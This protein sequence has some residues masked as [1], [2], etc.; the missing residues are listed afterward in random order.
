M[1]PGACSACFARRQCQGPSAAASPQQQARK[2]HSNGVLD[3]WDELG[4]NGSEMGKA[5]Q[6]RQAGWVDILSKTGR[7]WSRGSCKGMLESILPTA[8]AALSLVAGLA[9][10]CI[11]GCSAYTITT[12]LHHSDMHSEHFATQ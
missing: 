1:H 12:Q 11:K 7:T 8:P 4:W 10:S 6:A 5:M 9:L 2:V 3:K